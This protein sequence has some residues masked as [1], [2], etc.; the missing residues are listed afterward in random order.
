MPRR[1]RIYLAL[2][3]SGEAAWETLLTL[4]ALF[5]LFAL[6]KWRWVRARA[7]D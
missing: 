3:R 2:A 4:Y 1:L 5:A 6:W 7:P